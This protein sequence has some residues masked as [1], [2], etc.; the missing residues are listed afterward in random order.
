MTAD[1]WGGVLIGLAAILA[2][3]AIFAYTQKKPR[4]WT[5]AAGVGSV[6]STIAALFAGFIID[7]GPG[8]GPDEDLSAVFDAPAE[9]ADVTSPIDASGSAELTEG[10][11][12]WLLSKAPNGNYYTTTSNPSPV[13]INARGYW[14]VREVGL[15]K[16]SSDLPDPYELV[17]V[18]APSDDS[19]IEE[20]VQNRDGMAANLG[21][22][23]PEDTLELDRVAVT[24]TAIQGSTTSPTSIPTSSSTPTS[25]ASP[26]QAVLRFDSLGGG[27][28]Y[29]SVYPGVEDRPEDKISNGSFEHDQTAPALCRTT[30]RLV[31]SD[32]NA[33]EESRESD[34]WI[35]IEGSPNVVQYASL[36]YGEI[37]DGALEGLPQC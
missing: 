4:W 18:A 1:G 19:A 7:E 17:L 14:T 5:I 16:E 21:K 37:E 34:I 35:R 3:F 28:Q 11:V 27:S 31:V 13:D 12:L 23:L 33:G 26:S 24:L 22:R 29:I 6:L 10:W 8:P 25:S 20:A 32:T 2:A 15:G 9:D 30:G 36:T